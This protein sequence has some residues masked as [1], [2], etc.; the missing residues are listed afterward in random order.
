MSAMELRADMERPNRAPSGYT[1]RHGLDQGIGAL[2]VGGAGCEVGRRRREET[3]AA[4]GR[5]LWP[6]G[7]R[8][9]PPDALVRPE[10]HGPIRGSTRPPEDG[11]GLRGLPGGAEEQGV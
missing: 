9:R 1:P 10:V 2:D 11:G 6:V 7:L 4:H 3:S 5:P 8:P